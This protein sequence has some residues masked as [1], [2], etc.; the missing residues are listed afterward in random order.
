M[1]AVDPHKCLHCGL[2][3]G[4]CPQNAIFLLETALDFNDDCTNCG[5]CVR[6]CPVGALEMKGGN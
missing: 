2:C 5:R 6:L 1:I 4:S 3:S